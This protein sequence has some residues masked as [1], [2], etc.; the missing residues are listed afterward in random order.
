MSQPSDGAYRPRKPFITS[1]PYLIEG[2]V[3][4]VMVIENAD[5]EDSLYSSDAEMP[6]LDQKVRPQ[7]GHK[8]SGQA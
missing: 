2:Q 5:P 6:E 1:R 3:F 4:W 7:K 8:E